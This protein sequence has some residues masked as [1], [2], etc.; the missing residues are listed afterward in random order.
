[1]TVNTARHHKLV[2]L[3]NDVK[4]CRLDF[5]TINYVA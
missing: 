1:M 3:F 4:M 5:M 2:I